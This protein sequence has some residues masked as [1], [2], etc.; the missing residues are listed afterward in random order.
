MNSKKATVFSH[1]IIFICLV[2]LAGSVQLPGAFAQFAFP[3]AFGLSPYG[4]SGGGFG[5]FPGFGG[6]FGYGAFGLGGIYNPGFSYGASGFGGTFNP[7]FNN[8]FGYGASGFNP[9]FSTGFNYGSPSFSSGYNPGL[10]FGASGFGSTFNPGFNTGFGYGVPSFSG[11]YN[12]GLSFGA[13]G[14]GIPSYG[15]GGTFGGYSSVGF[16]T[17]L[18]YNTR[19]G[20][21]LGGFSTPAY[22][23][24][25][26]LTGGI[27]S[28]NSFQYNPYGFNTYSRTQKST[29]QQET[30]EPE[31]SEYYG[32][33]EDIPDLRGHW[34]GSWQAFA[35]DPNGMILSD[36]NGVVLID[37]QGDVKFY[38]TKQIMTG[39]KVE[40]TAQ[41]NNWNVEDYPT[42]DGDTLPVN[43]TG[44]IDEYNKW[45]FLHYFNIDGDELLSDLSNLTSDYTWMFT[46]L[47][48]YDNWFFGQFTVRGTGNYIM[49]GTF[50]TTKYTPK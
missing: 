33:L 34:S 22:G 18:P 30:E 4:F 27:S 26:G 49:V 35:T 36:P 13:F 38:I 45:L 31:T 46:N 1:I 24:L 21:S 43:V 37:V 16:G 50:K 20:A 5:A 17:A 6:G 40:G 12:P 23:M 11:G 15:L 41:I 48:I 28:F 42:W 25:G 7:G 3:G 29:K 8:G 32:D 2:L 39:G 44:W 19:F 10:S 9:G 47:R 14:F